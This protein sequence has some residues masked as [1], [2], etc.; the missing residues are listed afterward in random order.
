MKNFRTVPG[1]EFPSTTAATEGDEEDGDWDQRSYQEDGQDHQED[2]I[3][4]LLL[5]GLNWD[6]LIDR[7]VDRQTDR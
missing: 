2:H 5:L 3:T 6:L 7:W 4:I 1:T